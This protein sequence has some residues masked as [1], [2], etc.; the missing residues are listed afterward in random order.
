MIGWRE[1]LKRWTRKV[2]GYAALLLLGAS[3]LAFVLLAVALVL[4]ADWRLPALGA[5]AVVAA[6]AVRLA[7]LATLV[8]MASV[9]AAG[10]HHLMVGERTGSATRKRWLKVLDRLI[11]PWLA[12]FYPRNNR[13]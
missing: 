2:F 6:W 3:A 13:G 12:R 9:Y 8:G 4:P 7:A 1:R 5:A 11:P 10:E